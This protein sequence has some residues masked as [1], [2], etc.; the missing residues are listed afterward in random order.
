MLELIATLVLVGLVASHVAARVAM[1]HGLP[2]LPP[3]P[4][5]S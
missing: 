2:D 4:H 1:D 3:A 5:G